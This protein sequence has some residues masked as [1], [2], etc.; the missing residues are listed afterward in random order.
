[1]GEWCV[2][3]HK[4]KGVGGNYISVKINVNIIKNMLICICQQQV[5]LNV[6]RYCFRFVELTCLSRSPE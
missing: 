1:M 6:I 3:L 4:A 5:L 2:F